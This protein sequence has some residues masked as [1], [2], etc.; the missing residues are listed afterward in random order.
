MGV[1]VIV[2]CILGVIATNKAIK[3]L[4]IFCVAALA[5]P[6]PAGVVEAAVEGQKRVVS[7]QQAE[8]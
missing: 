4:P 3:L 8:I 2:S 7:V 1:A 6:A 5:F